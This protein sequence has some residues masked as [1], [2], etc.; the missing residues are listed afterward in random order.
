LRCA[1][2][3]SL[4]AYKFGRAAHH[5]LPPAF[6]RGKRIV[7][8]GD[9][10]LGRLRIKEDDVRRIAYRET[11]VPEVEQPCRALGEHG[12]ALPQRCRMP[13]LQH[14]GVQVRHA[15]QRAVPVGCRWIEHVVG[16]E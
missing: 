6:E 3:P 1:A 7:D 14:V 13:Q 2:N 11:I 4:R 9:R 15:D 8:L 5:G 16:G 12:K 10:F